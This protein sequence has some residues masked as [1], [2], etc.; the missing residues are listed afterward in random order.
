MADTAARIAL[1]ARRN[2]VARFMIVVTGIEGI[3]KVAEN[4]LQKA[5]AVFGVDTGTT[6]E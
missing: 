4:Y 1:C 2:E 3:F 5:G 6:P